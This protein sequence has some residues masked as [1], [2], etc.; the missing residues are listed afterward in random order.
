MK[1]ILCAIVL[2]QMSS[3]VFSQDY[4]LLDPSESCIL[5]SCLKDTDYSMSLAQA[6]LTD[7]TSTSSE[8]SLTPTDPNEVVVQWKVIR[9][10]NETLD[11]EQSSS[12]VDSGLSSV[13]INAAL[14]SVKSG[15]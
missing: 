11:S 7:E 12:T 15:K 5:T 14:K 4:G 2:S 10:L 9:R 3:V 6:A 1:K 8:A 13:L